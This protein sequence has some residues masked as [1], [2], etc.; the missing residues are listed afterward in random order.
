MVA[1]ARSTSIITEVEE[2]GSGERATGILVEV[3]EQGSGERVSSIVVLVEYV[4]LAAYAT[5][6]VVL[7]E[8]SPVYRPR[9]HF[10]FNG[11]DLTNY[12]D[13]LSLQIGSLDIDSTNL[14]DSSKSSKPGRTDQSLQIQGSWSTEVDNIIGKY[15]MFGA[16]EESIIRFENGVQRIDYRWSNGVIRNWSVRTNAV[17]KIEWSADLRLNGLGSRISS[18][19]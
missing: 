12:I 17:G 10:S 14:G 13:S 8:I 18:G 3:E 6:I 4:A 11:I 19:M 5:S 9:A 15:A 16:G 1:E 2:Q 7:V